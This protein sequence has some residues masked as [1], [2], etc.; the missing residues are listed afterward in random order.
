MFHLSVY[1]Y[2]GEEGCVNVG[3]VYKQELYNFPMAI[4]F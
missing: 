4:A 1:K 3:R 2:I